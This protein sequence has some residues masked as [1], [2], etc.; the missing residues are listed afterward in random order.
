MLRKQGNNEHKGALNLTKVLQDNWIR[1]QGNKTHFS[2][3]GSTDSRTPTS[4]RRRRSAGLRSKTFFWSRSV[5]QP[6]GRKDGHARVNPA[7]VSSRSRRMLEGIPPS[8][9]RSRSEDAH[10]ENSPVRRMVVGRRLPTSRCRPE[11]TRTSRG[12]LTKCSRAPTS[13]ARSLPPLRRHQLPHLH[14]VLSGL[15]QVTR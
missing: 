4:T 15:R 7:D 1:V 5:R 11:D 3:K 9:G 14:E 12:S 8:R 2:K 6:Y 10:H 13:K